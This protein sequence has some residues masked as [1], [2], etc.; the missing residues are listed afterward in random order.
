[1]GAS[2]FNQDGYLLQESVD[3]VAKFALDRFAYK[4]ID[5]GSKAIMMEVSHGH[6]ISG[7]GGF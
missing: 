3:D 7:E 2:S 5:V 1:M 4:F 6:I